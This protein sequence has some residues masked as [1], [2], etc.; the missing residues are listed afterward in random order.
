MDDKNRCNNETAAILEK[1]IDMVTDAEM[2]K[3]NNHVVSHVKA[4]KPK[5]SPQEAKR[6]KDQQYARK[7]A[8]E[9]WAGLAAIKNQ[10]Q[11]TAPAKP[12][13][14]FKNKK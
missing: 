7:V 12:N 5:L 11:Y 4:T 8:G 13:E 6:M 14:S 2:Q 3:F 9:R 1:P 10:I